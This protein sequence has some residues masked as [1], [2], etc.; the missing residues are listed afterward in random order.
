MRR[1][2]IRH[3][4]GRGAAGR[5]RRSPTVH[6]A[7]CPTAVPFFGHCHAGG[8]AI[9]DRSSPPEAGS[10]LAALTEL[11]LAD[12][13]AVPADLR[14]D[15]AP[16]ARARAAV[17][18]GAAHPRARDR[19]APG[20]DPAAH[21]FR[22]FRDASDR[23]CRSFRGRDRSS[24]CRSSGPITSS[25]PDGT[26]TH[27]EFLHDTIGDP[28]R[29]FAASLLAATADAAALVVYSSFEAEVLGA[30]AEEL[31]DLAA[32][33]LDRRAASSTSCRSFAIIVTTRICVARFRSRACSRRSCPRSAT[34][35]SRSATGS[36]HRSRT[37]AS[38]IR[39]SIRGSGRATG[40]QLLAYCRRDTEAMLALYHAL[41]APLGVTDGAAR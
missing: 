23:P 35:I 15:R 17:V 38:S 4:G 6:T 2:L 26:V 40:S 3:A 7:S 41:G 11:A 37:R 25:P 22:R 21:P 39:R 28:R 31:P 12:I 24:G 32:G 8:G 1:R 10:Q 5:L 19:R 30:L 13:R 33:L 20:G 36:R 14:A 16:A 29:A 27:H 18:A 9:R 34:A